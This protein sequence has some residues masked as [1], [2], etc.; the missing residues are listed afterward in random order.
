MFV[1]HCPIFVQITGRCPTN[2][3]RYAIEVSISS[4]LTHPHA[5]DNIHVP[6]T[7]T[8]T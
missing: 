8:H 4:W 6:H 2:M 3:V 5:E 7:L 1:G